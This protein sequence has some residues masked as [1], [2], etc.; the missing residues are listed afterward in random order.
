MGVGALPQA[1]K[2]QL[3]TNRGGGSTLRRSATTEHTVEQCETVGAARPARDEGRRPPLPK[4]GLGAVAR[5][6][7]VVQAR[8][9]DV[10]FAHARQL[11][12]VGRVG[13]P[14]TQRLRVRL[15]VLP[16]R[17]HRLGG[18]ARRPAQHEVDVGDELVELLGAPHE[19]EVAQDVLPRLQQ[20]FAW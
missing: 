17:A 2:V 11:R 7:G 4:H 16:T 3:G 18:Q 1:Q 13:H 10:G 12:R 15:L 9:E 5:A 8:V 20:L 19:R 6:K 14:A